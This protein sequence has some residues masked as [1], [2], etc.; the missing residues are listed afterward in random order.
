M[1][2]SNNLKNLGHHSLTDLTRAFA[3]AIPTGGVCNGFTSMWMQA[4]LTNQRQEEHFYQ[5][6][7]TLSAYL[8]KPENSIAL[9]KQEIDIMYKAIRHTATPQIPLSMDYL[10][11]EALEQIELRAFAESVAMQQ[12]PGVLNI[13]EKNVHFYQKSTLYSYTHSAMLENGTH[14]R[15][16]TELP[17]DN[18][19]EPSKMY[20]EKIGSQLKYVLLNQQEEKIEAFLDISIDSL[21]KESLAKLKPVIL[22]ETSKRG[23]T[24]QL[25]SDIVG[26]VAGT[27][28]ELE[29]Y[30][31][32]IQQELE[33]EH[34]LNPGHQKI[35]FLLS[36]DNHTVGAYLNSQNTKWHFLDINQLS[37]KETY[38]FSVDSAM[39][40]SL[41][42]NAFFD[43]TVLNS[44]FSVNCI[45]TQ[46][47]EYFI[48]TLK[49]ISNT[50]LPS[51][52]DKMS[53]RKFNTLLLASIYGETS[54]VASLV[55]AGAKTSSLSNKNRTPLMLAAQYGHLTTVK[56][57]LDTKKQRPQGTFR[58]LMFTAQNALEFCSTL[59]GNNL[60][61]VDNL[62]YSALMYAAE[63]GYTDVI[64]LLVGRGANTSLKNKLGNTAL[65]LAAQNGR[66]NVVE[67]L[68]NQQAKINTQ[69]MQGNTALMLAAQNGRLNVVEY[70]INQ[71]AKINTQNMQGNTALMLATENGQYSIVSILIQHKASFNVVNKFGRTALTLAKKNNHIFITDLLTDIGAS[72]YKTWSGWLKDSLYSYKKRNFGESE[73]SS[74]RARI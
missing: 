54:T 60:N 64:C 2:D 1:A 29:Q 57:L 68:I 59:M 53:S 67:Y 35:G 8:S 37:G 28:Q 51:T 74:K 63:S 16:M 30:F 47:S 70:L 3:P 21:T 62:G 4:V 6:L 24:I 38:Y 20:I 26:I 5:R 41:L 73:P 23:H 7:D 56:A 34:A 69:N 33:K 44:V 9:L 14:L 55:T 46:H 15:L 12:N 49:T 25:K 22:E 11:V 27:K 13:F 40:A 72:E 66:L 58:A 31:N 19:P 18:I 36:S 10:P 61:Q 32:A 39:L 48:A 65:M 71:Q 45:S 50:L 17:E 43:Q 52:I 42:F